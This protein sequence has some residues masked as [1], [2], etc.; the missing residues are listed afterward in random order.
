MT[1]AARELSGSNGPTPPTIDA[2][3]D[4]DDADSVDDA[5]EDRPHPLV[6]EKPEDQDGAAPAEDEGLLA[7]GKARLWRVLDPLRLGAWQRLDSRARA[8]RYPLRLVLLLAQRFVSERLLVRAS[9][10]A[11]FTVLSLVPLLVVAVS[12]IVAFG[13]AGGDASQTLRQLQ[14]LLLPALG[15]EISEYAAGALTRATEAG[16][17]AAGVLVLVFT[18]VMLFFHIER[19]FNDTWHVTER[20]PIYVRV[21]LFYSLITLGPLLLSISLY[22][23]AAIGEAFDAG[24]FSRLTGSIT[25][26]LINASIFLIIFKLVPNTRVRWRYAIIA[27]LITSVLFEIAKI[28]FSMYARESM[29]GD[30]NVIYGSLVILPMVM[31][32]IYVSWMVVLLGNQ[33]AY[34]MQHMHNLMLFDSPEH[35]QLHV[36]AFVG[37]SLVALEVF[38]PIARAYV[39]GEGP[40][41]M[42]RICADARQHQRAVAEILDRLVDAGLVL[43][44]QSADRVGYLPARPPDAIALN[45]IVA[46]FELDLGKPRGSRELNQIV[47]RA[48]KARE[49]VLGGR[50][51]RDLFDAAPRRRR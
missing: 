25:P 24:F 31:V 30:Y 37:S 39:C 4:A 12:L 21:L 22:H 18:A 50:T 6:L 20:R 15:P 40:A 10:L 43:E 13:G 17:G 11:F 16:I 32:W 5:A 46:P 33:V 51:A 38:T 36:E 28:A 49:E 2:R 1:D 35:A 26:F 44:V 19:V 23:A 34:C 8:R 42:D 27:A 14:R 41:A 9:S 29:R 3:P 47:A 7:R 48:Q 45:D